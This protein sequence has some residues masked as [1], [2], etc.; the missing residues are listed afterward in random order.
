MSTNTAA[1]VS[2]QLNLTTLG[3]WDKGVTG[4]DMPGFADAVKEFQCVH[5]LT[6]D[7]VIGSKT[8]AHFKKLIHERLQLLVL[9][10]SATQEGLPV[11]AERIVKYHLEN[12]KWSRPGYRDIIE[13]DGKLVN[14][15]P[16]NDDDLVNHWEVTNGMLTA[17]NRNAAHI[18]YIGGIDKSG[19]AKDTRTPGQL[20][21]MR[22]YILKFLDRYRDAVIIGHNAV[23]Q[24]GCPCFNVPEY[25]RSIGVSERNIGSFRLY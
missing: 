13:I 4:K 2:N 18:C 3:Y 24:K 10:C 21:T 6:A 15:H 19:K 17:F 20:A 11:S 7:G 5:G 22:D 25:L 8:R 12:R 14:I 16:Y 9:H 23:Q 1:I